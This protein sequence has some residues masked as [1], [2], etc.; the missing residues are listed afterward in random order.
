MIKKIDK[1]FSILDEVFMWLSFLTLGG[2]TLLITIQVICRFILKAP[3]A[4]SVELASF[5]FIWMTF[6][7]GYLGA[8]RAQHISVELVQNLFPAAVKKS[9]KCISALITSAFF[10]MVVYYLLTLWSKLAAQ[11]SA[12][13]NIPMNYIYLGMLIGCACLGLSYLYDAVKIWLPESGEAQSDE[14]VIS[15]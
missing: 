5:G 2:M 4:W 8:R 13:L 6:F 14:G 11:T 7:A 10:L 1:F 15:E 9:M 3:L 12:A